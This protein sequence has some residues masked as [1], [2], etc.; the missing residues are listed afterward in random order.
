MLAQDKRYNLSRNAVTHNE[1]TIAPVELRSLIQLVILVIALLA[2][3]FKK[4]NMR[5]TLLYG[6][7]I[8]LL[9]N[10]L[11]PNLVKAQNLS[12]YCEQ[13][14]NLQKELLT[15]DVEA[16]RAIDKIRLSLINIYMLKSAGLDEKGT[17]AAALGIVEPKQKV[18]DNSASDIRSQL[19]AIRIIRN[20]CVI[21]ERDLSQ[22]CQNYLNLLSR[23]QQQVKKRVVLYQEVADIKI[24]SLLDLKKIEKKADILISEIPESLKLMQ[25]AAGNECS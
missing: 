6:I 9:S 16:F 20:V 17:V 11:S 24:N 13:Q 25:E 3:F 21:S 7:A 14:S 4:S 2:Y 12:P 10:L 5:T 8:F 18:L 22:S 15:L 23:F 19:G 1:D